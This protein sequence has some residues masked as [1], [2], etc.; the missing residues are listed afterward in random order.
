MRYPL[1]FKKNKEQTP[2]FLFNLDKVNENIDFLVQK[3]KKLNFKILY[4]T[5]ALPLYKILK[6]LEPKVSGFSVSSLFE[7]LLA[8]KSCQ[9]KKDIHFVSPG[10]RKEEWNDISNIVNSLTFNSFEQY[11]F[12]RDRLSKKSSYGIRINP[13]ISVSKDSR[14]DPCRRFSKLGV[15]LD[16]FK[17]KISEDYNILKNIEGIHLHTNCESRDFSHLTKT[18]TKVK[19]KIGDDLKKI[20]WINL[21]GGYFFDQSKNIS[22][23]NEVIEDIA[24]NYRFNEIIIEPGGFIVANSGYLVSTVI[25]LFRRNGKNI[26]ILDT[27]IN[28]LPEVFEYQYEPNILGHQEHHKN[29]YILAGRSCLAGDIFGTYH[30]EEKL[31]TGSQ[32]IFENVGHYTLVKANTFNGINLPDVYYV[33]NGSDLKKIKSFTFKEYANYFGG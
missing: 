1:W 16:E 2:F 24:K 32:L 8:E 25:D 23:F 21:G 31:E 20:K 3:T 6:E 15:T 11:F 4:S 28:H 18:F 27:T 9:D 10:I 29:E 22:L 12:Y 14:Y 13:E 19:E 26:A 7:A 5:K 30:F 17:K 33:K